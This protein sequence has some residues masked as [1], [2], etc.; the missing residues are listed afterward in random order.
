MDREASHV[1][2]RQQGSGI[3]G[4]SCPTSCRTMPRARSTAALNAA[5]ARRLCTRLPILRRSVANRR[6]RPVGA[7]CS[8]PVSTRGAQRSNPVYAARY[9]HLTTHEHN[10]LTAI[11]AQTGLRLHGVV[12]GD[13]R[14]PSGNAMAALHVPT[15]RWPGED[16]VHQRLGLVCGPDLDGDN[17]CRR[18]A[19]ETRSPSACLDVSSLT[20]GEAPSPSPV[21]STRDC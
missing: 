7:Q 21:T 11:Q 16:V 6:R 14:A 8:L 18:L 4:P 13:H 1:S 5:L 12:A 10:K 19:T 2:Q 20:C 9:Q 3:Y 15:T 17:V